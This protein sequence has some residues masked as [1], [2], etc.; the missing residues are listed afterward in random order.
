MKEK[1]FD[2]S[3]L[4]ETQIDAQVIEPIDTS[5]EFENKITVRILGTNDRHLKCY[6]NQ[7][8]IVLNPLRFKK[9]TKKTKLLLE[10]NTTAYF[11]NEFLEE[12]KEED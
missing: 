5:N 3:K 6:I 7:T 10:D 11:K 8:G 9:G 1:D 2:V 4:L 12:I